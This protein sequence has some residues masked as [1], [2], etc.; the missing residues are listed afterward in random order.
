MIRT[1]VARR[2]SARKSS[3]STS[4]RTA[5]E[6]APGWARFTET[7]AGDISRAYRSGNGSQSHALPAGTES[8]SV[9]TTGVP[10]GSDGAAGIGAGPAQ[11]DTAT[12]SATAAV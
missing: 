5:A 12:A 6:V 7:A 9:T 11:P 8:P 1:M 3:A 10:G 2:R 4:S